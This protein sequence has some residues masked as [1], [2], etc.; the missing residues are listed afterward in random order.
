MMRMMG[1]SG[2]KRLW[3]AFAAAGTFG[4]CVAEFALPAAGPVPFRRFAIPLDADTMTRLSQD[5]TAAAREQPIA[6]PHERRAVV[7]LLALAQVLDPANDAA[8]EILKACA[9]GSHN[10]Q[11]DPAGPARELVRIRH[12]ASWLELPEAGPDGQ[13]LAHCLQDVLAAS[14]PGHPDAQA[15]RE[16]GEAG[17]WAGWVPEPAAYE[18]RPKVAEAPATRPPPGPEPGL[19]AVRLPQAS[20]GTLAWKKS[21][22]DPSA[23]WLPVP[24]SLSMTSSLAEDASSGFSLS[25]G[26]QGRSLDQ[27]AR[28]IGNLLEK[29]HGDLPRGLRIR[30]TCPEFSSSPEAGSALPS[31]AA[32]AVLA[33]A[34]I[35]GREADAIILGR[36]DESGALTLP[37][38][39]WEQLLSLGPG[40]G[41]RLV[42]PAA[43]ADWLPSVLAME[44]PGFFMDYEVLLAADFRELLD[45]SAKEPPGN[46]AAASAKFREIRERMGG[47]DVRS[48]VANSFVRTRLGELAQE[49]APY[50]ASAAMLFMQAGG[51]RPTTLIRPALNAELLI[52]AKPLAWITRREEYEFD[53]ADPKRWSECYDG[54]RKRIDQLAR[55]TT[56]TDQ[57]LLEEGRAVSTAA[58]NLERAYRTRGEQYLVWGAVHRAR[59][60]FSRLYRS[61]VSRLTGDS[62]PVASP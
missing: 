30:I 62:E 16:T 22:N 35:T 59:R 46:V 33:S 49:A 29:Q 52:A 9:S 21:G 7:Q 27:T 54:Y 13:A 8:R 19:P 26:G 58:R 42:L 41:R 44:K 11:K 40:K 15:R 6:T 43:A 32:A 1:N 34:A 36:V 61:H 18:D 31:S 28:M 38:T 17:A 3:A 47:E 37:K 25:F 39:I 4:I 2:R 50:H 45:L 14:D 23:E 53:A 55:M 60:D 24:T 51:K 12:L 20:V 5:L 10:P 57:D 56:R 48:Y